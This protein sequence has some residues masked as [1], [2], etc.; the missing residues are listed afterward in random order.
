MCLTQKNERSTWIQFNRSELPTMSR[1][2]T[3]ESETEVAK[4]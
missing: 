1:L 4:Y 2:R 3:K